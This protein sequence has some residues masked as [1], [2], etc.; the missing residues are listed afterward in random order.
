MT[1][2]VVNK[3]LNDHSIIAK[4]NK[5][6]DEKWHVRKQNIIKQLSLF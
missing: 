6:G 1:K 5:E 4:I 2:S 3:K